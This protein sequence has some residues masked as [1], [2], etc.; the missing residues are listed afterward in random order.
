VELIDKP[1]KFTI[2]KATRTL[3]FKVGKNPQPII[4]RLESMA[5]RFGYNLTICQSGKTFVAKFIK[6]I[7]L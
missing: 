4:N 2:M 1:F 7:N 3:F 5:D 6:V